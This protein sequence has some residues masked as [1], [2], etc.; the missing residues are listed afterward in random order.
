V[1]LV[2][3]ANCLNFGARKGVRTASRP[4]SSPVVARISFVLT[5]SGCVW[6]PAREVVGSVGGTEYSYDKSGKPFLTNE[7]NLLLNDNN[8]GKVEGIH[9]MIGRRPLAAFGNTAGNRPV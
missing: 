2:V 1:A 3:V 4:T 7:P 5:P 9:L 6:H 8:A